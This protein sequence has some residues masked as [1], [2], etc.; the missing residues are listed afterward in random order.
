MMK[1][2]YSE[3]PRWYEKIGQ[4]HALLERVKIS[5][6]EHDDVL[7]LR[8][9]NRIMSIHASTAIEGNRLSLGQVQAV[10]NGA[11]VFG[12][13]KDIKEVQNAWA[14]YND[15]ENLDPWSVT[16]LLK[17]HA[18]LTNDLVGESGAFRTVGVAV[19]RG[20]GAVMHRGADPAKV[21]LLVDE[22]LKWGKQ[23]EVH[24]LIKSSAL[25][26]MI[27]HIHPF[28]D[29]NGRIGRLWQTLVLSRW[30]PLFEW[31]PVETLIHYNQALYYQA[32]QDSH[33]AQV[34]CRPFIPLGYNTPPLCGG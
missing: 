22:L 3:S 16:S 13:P 6:E 25:H 20:D 33:S 34:D 19:V 5:E 10:V 15:M 11:P 9:L 27:E 31:M 2:F 8:K 17:A 7:H 32:L 4:I 1:T 30:N 18:L 24:P 14:A 28:R 12:P 21:P 29:G 26:F 23:S